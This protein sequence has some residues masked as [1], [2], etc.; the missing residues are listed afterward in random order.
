MTIEHVDGKNAGKL[1]LYALSTCIWCRKTKQLLTDLGVEYD[2]VFVDLLQGQEKEQTIAIVEKWNPD[3]S[4]P[5]LVVNDSKC[6]VG[7]KENEIKEALKL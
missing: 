4:F 7:F 5:T 3:C 1:M 6:I 2:Y